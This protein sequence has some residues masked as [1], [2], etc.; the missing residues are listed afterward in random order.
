MLNPPEAMKTFQI[1]YSFCSSGAIFF[2][3]CEILQLS[4]WSSFISF[5]WLGTSDMK[6][7]SSSLS[8]YES[9]ESF[10]SIFVF[11]RSSTSSSCQ[12]LQSVS[13]VGLHDFFIHVRSNALS[14]GWSSYHTTTLIIRSC[15]L[16][17]WIN[18]ISLIPR[19]LEVAFIPRYFYFRPYFSGVLSRRK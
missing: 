11:L 10:A 14:A 18:V 6:T 19:K 15:T 8:I 16:N 3:I 17:W 4:P 13:V 12:H 7:T 5:R 2:Y 9:G 1:L